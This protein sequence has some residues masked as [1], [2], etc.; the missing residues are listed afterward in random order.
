MGI[1]G[2]VPEDIADSF[3]RFPTNRSGPNSHPLSRSPPSFRSRRMVVSSAL[4]ARLAHNQRLLPIRLL[5][6]GSTAGSPSPSLTRKAPLSPSMFQVQVPLLWGFLELG[7]DNPRR[8]FP[9]AG[10]GSPVSSGGCLGRIPA[11]HLVP[12]FVPERLSDFLAEN[13]STGRV[14]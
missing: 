12:A 1:G 4:R 8:L 2:S 7:L 14:P 3:S 9:W 6:P 13:S 11:F 5:P 10:E